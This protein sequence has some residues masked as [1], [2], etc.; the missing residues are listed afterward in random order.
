VFIG[1]TLSSET[2]AAWSGRSAWCAATRMAIAAVYRLPRGRLL[3]HWT[4]ISKHGDGDE[5]KLPAI[6]QVNWF[7]S[8]SRRPVSV[9]GFARTRGCLKWDRRAPGRNA[10]AVDT[11]IG[12]VPTPASI[13][14]AA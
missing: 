8:Q 10:D 3:R 13:D 1:A 4:E 9:A 11:P 2:T 7:R 14:T 5:S 12:Y 6:F